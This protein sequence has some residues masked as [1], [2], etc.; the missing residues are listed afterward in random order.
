MQLFRENLKFVKHLRRSHISLALKYI[1]ICNRPLMFC[2]F[3][4]LHDAIFP[5]GQV[6]RQPGLHSLS[7]PSS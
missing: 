7:S 4:T 1:S 6:L 2:H 3:N 5:C